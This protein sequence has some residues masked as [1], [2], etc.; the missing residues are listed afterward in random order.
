MIAVFVGSSAG[1]AHG[2]TNGQASS[3]DLAPIATGVNCDRPAGEL[4]KSAAAGLNTAAL[5]AQK[6]LPINGCDSAY[7]S[8]ARQV[9]WRNYWCGQGNCGNAAVPGTSNHGLGL[10]ID[11]PA[12]V[13]A[14][15][16]SSHA[17]YGFWKPCSD[18]PQESWHL[19]FCASFHRPDP[20]VH[21]QRPV[22]RVGSGG[23]GQQAWVKK[24]QKLLNKHG[25]KVH[26]DGDFGQHTKDAVKV[27]QRASKIPSDGV[28]GKRTWR[29]LRE[30]VVLPRPPPKPHTAPSH[31][32]PVYGVDVS[33]HQGNIH[34]KAVADEGHKAFAIVK[35]TEGEDYRDPYFGKARLS[36]IKQ[37]HLVPGVYHFLRPRAG[38]TGSKE[39]RFFIQTITHAGYGKGFL[40]P[41]VDFEA[42]TL[43]PEAT[44]RYGHS[45]VRRVQ[46][47]LHLHAIIY[48]YPGFA[49]AYGGAACGWLD[50]YRLWIANPGVSSP[51]HPAPWS[52]HLMW[53][54]SFEGRVPG[55]S[56]AVDLDKLPGG[57]DTLH[58]LMVQPAEKLQEKP[59]AKVPAVR[60]E[61]AKPERLRKEGPE[62]HAAQRRSVG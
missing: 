60:S 62:Q 53:Q 12:W 15:F 16:D 39:A 59:K 8:F 18:A 7:R 25:A 61:V 24:A 37:A 31:K 47:K 54:Y 13:R 30:P 56:T 29:H 1:T 6:Q 17:N 43:G 36:S 23:P 11:V 20:G 50:N 41:V 22:L 49:T 33:E 45:F 51:S 27:F 21:L 3:S 28:V 32:G 55:I 9:Y 2:F 40:P 4:S 46:A 57:Y 38:R 26:V 42:T 44:C 34:W 14:Y 48:T 58:K 10:A 5:A 35:A 52:A 19:K